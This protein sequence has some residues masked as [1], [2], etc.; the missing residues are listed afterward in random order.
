MPNNI[1][2]LIHNFLRLNTNIIPNTYS[3]HWSSKNNNREYFSTRSFTKLLWDN[4]QQCR[5]CIDLFSLVYFPIVNA[6]PTKL[7][8][9]NDRGE[10]SLEEREFTLLVFWYA[11]ELVL[12]MAGMICIGF[13][14][15]RT[16]SKAY[17]NEQKTVRDLLSSGVIG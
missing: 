2:M 17:F 6:M 16:V 9:T 1:S 13:G 11:C 10:H 5:A 15:R 3:N 8:T 12:S 7:T 4:V 14:W